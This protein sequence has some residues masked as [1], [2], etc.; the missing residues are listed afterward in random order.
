MKKTKSVD[1]KKRVYNMFDNP[2]V[3]VIEYTYTY[4]DN[5][6]SYREISHA[7]RKLGWIYVDEDF[8]TKKYLG[9]HTHV[10]SYFYKKAK[11]FRK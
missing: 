10:H 4:I 8:Y 11:G 7:P 5:V 1:V 2:N 3:M 6:T 9:G